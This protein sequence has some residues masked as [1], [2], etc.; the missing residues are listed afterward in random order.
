MLPSGGAVLTL[1]IVLAVAS[2]GN[3]LDSHSPGLHNRDAQGV[4]FW[5]LHRLASSTALTSNH[6]A[7]QSWTGVSQIPLAAV[8]PVMGAAPEF[9]AETFT[10]PQLTS[11]QTSSW[12]A[13]HCNRRGRNKRGRPLA[14]PGHGYRGH[15][16]TRDRR[17]RSRA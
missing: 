9:S 14:F 2:S 5:K 7:T 8:V 6:G 12:R 11:L 10:Q 16:G 1:I 3:A 15:P 13:G 4:N 17:S